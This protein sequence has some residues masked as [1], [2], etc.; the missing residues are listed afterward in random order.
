MRKHDKGESCIWSL[1]NCLGQQFYCYIFK[2]TTI[3]K[4]KRLCSIKYT[5][6]F[7]MKIPLFGFPIFLKLFNIVFCCKKEKCVLWKIF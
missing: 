7:F 2:T 3:K 4:K 1:Q 6:K 5:T